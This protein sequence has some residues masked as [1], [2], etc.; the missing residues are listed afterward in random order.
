MFEDLRDSA[1]SFI[2]VRINLIVLMVALRKSSITENDIFWH[3]I[4][5]LDQDNLIIHEFNVNLSKTIKGV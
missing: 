1:M 5:I 3:G 4:L 2:W